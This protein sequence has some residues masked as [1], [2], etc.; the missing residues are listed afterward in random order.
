[1]VSPT[2]DH[3]KISALPWRP[4]Q[5]SALSYLHSDAFIPDARMPNLSWAIP[6]TD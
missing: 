6:S 4:V 2:F 1:M 3:R 5:P